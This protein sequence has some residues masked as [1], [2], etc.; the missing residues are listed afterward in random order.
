MQHTY[1]VVPCSTKHIRISIFDFVAHFF[2]VFFSWYP[3]SM[4]GYIFE[5][6][7]ILPELGDI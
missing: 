1:I 7:K 2:V 6:R 4:V 3:Y 5:V